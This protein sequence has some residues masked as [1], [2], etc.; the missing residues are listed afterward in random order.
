[1]AHPVRF[2]LTTYSFG[3]Y[4]SIHLSYGCVAV[5][6]APTRNFLRC[7]ASTCTLR[8]QPLARVLM[9]LAS[10]SI[11]SAFFTIASDSTL[12]ESVFSTS[13]FNSLAS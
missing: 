7:C 12:A 4:R 8:F 5:S 1:M 13:S 2:E 9:S 11:S 10:F 3:G 6:L